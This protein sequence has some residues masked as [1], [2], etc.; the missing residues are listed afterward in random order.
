MQSAKEFAQTVYDKIQ[1]NEED[2]NKIQDILLFFN[3]KKSIIVLVGINLILYALYFLGLS[4]Y[5]IFFLC[6]GL[7]FASPFYLPVILPI[8]RTFILGSKTEVI[9]DPNTERYTV[10][11]FSAF[12]GT[13]KY[14]FNAQLINARAGIENKSSF[15]MFGTLF[16][17]NF[18]FFLFLSVPDPITIFLVINGCLLLPMLLQK[19]FSKQITQIQE[20]GAQIILDFTNVQEKDIKL[21]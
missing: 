6:L 13:V 20:R 19:S 21:E 15:L 18:L 16:V 12:C 7:Y 1:P 11:E 4:C 10:Q 3:K 17:L 8:L 2:F 14:Q 5:S 9:L